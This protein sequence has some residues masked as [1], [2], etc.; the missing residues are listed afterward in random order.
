MSGLSRESPWP[1]PYETTTLRDDEVAR[2]GKIVQKG[3]SI[4]ELALS[5]ECAPR[6]PRGLAGLLPPVALCEA[7]VPVRA[8]DD[9]IEYG[10]AAEFANVPQPRGELDVLP[11]RLGIARGVV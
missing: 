9:V 2:E 4:G 3:P 1:I 5:E 10:D 7:D 6:G 8:H 11:R